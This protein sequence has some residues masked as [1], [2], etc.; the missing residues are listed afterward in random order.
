MLNIAFFSVVIGFVFFILA[1]HAARYALVPGAKA[2]VMVVLAASSYAI[3]YLFQISSP[4]QA[5]AIFWYNVSLP[6]ANLLAPA[7]FVFA[8][9]WSGLAWKPTK[10][11][12]LIV[13]IVPALVCLAA[14]TNP[15]HLLYGANFNFLRQGSWGLLE[16]SVG[17]WY[18]VGFVYAYSLTVAAIIILMRSTWGR[19]RLYFYLTL[20]LVFGAIFPG[21]MNILSIAGFMPVPKLDLT[22]FSFLVTGLVWSLVF[23]WY[24]LLNIVPVARDRVYANMPIGMLVLDT[25]GRVA[26]IN[27]AGMDMLESSGAVQV[28]R[29][30]PYGLHDFF[31][32]EELRVVREEMD[33]TVCIGQNNGRRCLEIH[34]SPIFD[35]GGTLSG[36]L[37][38]M[39]DI[40]QRKL[41]GDALRESESKLRSVFAAM[42][43]VIIIYDADGGYREIAPTN[44][45]LYVKPPEE[46]LGK[47]VSEV[48]APEQASFFLDHIHQALALGKLTGVEYSL[49][50]NQKDLWFSAN[51]SAISSNTVLWVAR[52][53]TARKLIE[54]TSQESA[55]RLQ[56]A[57]AIA[58]LGSWELS[59]STNYFLAS[60]EAMRIYGFEPGQSISLEQLQALALPEERARLDK[61]FSELWQG[62]GTYDQEYR[63]RRVNEEGIRV[64]HVSANLESTEL[65]QPVKIFG[66]IQDITERKMA[67][68]ELHETENRYRSVVQSATDAIL[69]TDASGNLVSWNQGAQN[70]FQYSQAE[71][72]GKPLNILMP[73]RYRDAHEAG[74][75]KVAKGG[76]AQHLGQTLLMAGLRKDG[77]EFPVELVLSSWNDEGQIYFTGI[78]RDVTERQQ[79]QATLLYQSTHDTLTGLY[80][81]QYYETEIERLQ[82]SR[83]FPVSILMMDVDDLKIV[84]DVLGHHAGDDLLRNMA[85]VLKSTFRPEDMIGR[86]GGDEFVVI[87]PD[88]DFQTA[89]QAMQRLKISLK[90][91]NL[92]HGSDG[93]PLSLSIGLASGDKETL[94]SDVFKEADKA[95]YLDKS[96]K[97]QHPR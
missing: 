82:Q 53:I 77:D 58:H 66:V 40:T 50:I 5:S 60:D 70:I 47:T 37:L 95:M 64:V 4:D 62:L 72:L 6:G 35:K 68:K 51:I 48:F 93:Q 23:F 36:C 71:I 9:A 7:W 57:Q 22:P 87:L 14:W 54:K 39:V 67:E 2:L 73:A 8:L 28:G 19:A 21:V 10:R 49:R 15:L 3:A 41:A 25:Q 86:I 81:R 55:A 20:L 18:R 44:P 12:I 31:S 96:L 33:E 11:H 43:D 29:E 76:I 61:A 30:L 27:P 42:S 79:L 78:L 63:I 84:N 26:D 52:D 32:S 89:G 74:M 75:N 65:G 91:Y 45:A 69:I 94:L 97:K 59:I 24:R 92:A 17:F 85:T 56:Q 13:G 46:L 90:E 88:A 1:F 16:W 38:L 34:L 80:N 83:R